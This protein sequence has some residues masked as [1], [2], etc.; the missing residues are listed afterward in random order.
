M[1]ENHLAKWL[2]NE[3]SEAELEEFKNSPGY[4]S[5]ERIVKAAEDL[6]SPDFDVEKALKDLDTRKAGKASGVIRLNPWKKVLRIAAVIAFIFALSLVYLST[7]EETISTRYA[8]R[9]EV[10][11]PDASEVWL[12]AGSEISYDKRNWDKERRVDL[13]GEAFFKVA[14]GKK[15][16][17]ATSTGTVMV[18]GTRFN[19]ENR[20]KY[21]EVSC[22]EGLVRVTYRGESRELPAG[23]SFLA[24][25][26]KI[27]PIRGPGANTPSWINN[28]STFQSTP[29]AYV[30]AEFERQYNV[31]V[32]TRNV[33]LDQL[34]TGSFSNTNIN[35]ALQ[36]ISAPSQ[37]SFILEGNKVLFYAGN[38]P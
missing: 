9:T 2:N 18:L 14:K 24:I 3:L 13:K 8:Q 23:T 26:G 25:D 21:F 31:E 12:N 16:S 36:S 4:A 1:K 30:L 35:L 32:N 15:F 34:Y 22:F 7:L 20:G 11:L 10:V 29:L 19:V 37:I 5:Y 27:M 38:T 28:E 17:V 33:N 6:G